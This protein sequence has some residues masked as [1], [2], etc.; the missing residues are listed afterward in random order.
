MQDRLL[1]D[2]AIHQMRDDIP[3]FKEGSLI[4][5]DV[6]IREGNKER[7]QAFEGLVIAKRGSGLN[8]TFVVRKVSYGVAVERV[9]FRH[10]PH[11]SSIKVLRI[12]KVRRAKLYYMR[13]LQGK[14]MRLKEIRKDKN[15]LVDA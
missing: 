5:V 9:F 15:R 2:L 8:E 13:K 6:K 7:I 1:E 11:I 10:S 14:M 3:T 4:R 12:N